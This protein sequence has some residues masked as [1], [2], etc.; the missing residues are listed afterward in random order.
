MD[1]RFMIERLQRM[2]DDIGNSTVYGGNRIS[3]SIM[4]KIRVEERE[5]G[6]GVLA[7]YWLPVT[8]KGRGPRKSNADSG[9]VRR[10]YAWMEKNNMFDS[11]SPKG[12]MNEAKSMTWYINKYGNKQFRDG[13]FV[14]VYNTARESAI[15]DIMEEYGALTVTIT[16]EIL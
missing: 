4:D 3:Q 10:I 13:V 11:T 16:K 2:V 12:K 15:K 8:E 7:P 6:A 5:N 1:R 14:D 9:L